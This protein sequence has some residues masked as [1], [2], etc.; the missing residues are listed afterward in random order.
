MEKEEGNPMRRLL[1]LRPAAL[2]CLATCFLLSSVA[3]GP[4]QEVEWRTDYAAARK[5]ASDKNLPLVID[6]STENCFY[7]KRLDATT[8]REPAIS[9]LMNERFIPLKIDAGRDSILAERLAIQVYPTLLFASP[10]GRILDRP[11]TG[12]VEPA[13]FHEKLRA[14]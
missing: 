7:C 5:E 1:A 4:A 14:I 8:F 10:D 12:Y 11:V 6:F 3:P 2:G 9:T 13:A